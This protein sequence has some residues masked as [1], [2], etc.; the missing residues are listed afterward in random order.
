MFATTFVDIHH[1]KKSAW[2]GI[3]PV[4]KIYEFLWKNGGCI[5]GPKMK[6]SCLTTPQWPQKQNTSAKQNV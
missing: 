1:T 5:C 2:Y 3:P 4:S 6:C